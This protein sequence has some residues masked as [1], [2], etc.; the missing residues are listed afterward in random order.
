[1][2]FLIQRKIVNKKNENSKISVINKIDDHQG[3]ESN[4]KLVQNNSINIKKSDEIDIQSNKQI[5]IRKKNQ[6]EV[7]FPKIIPKKR[8][9][10]LPIV[11]DIDKTKYNQGILKLNSS[12]MSYYH[13]YF[14]YQLSRNLKSKNKKDNIKFFLD[15][16]RCIIKRKTNELVIK[17]LYKFYK[18]F[19]PK[20]GILNIN[21][22]IQEYNRDSKFIT[23][24]SDSKKESEFLEPS[25]LDL[26]DN[27]PS[28]LI[29]N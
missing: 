24:K 26:L 4:S 9:I 18:G 3:N 2:E 16:L 27:T 6:S 29:R 8:K 19:S 7:H 10:N 14:I 20:R 5:N 12:V 17:L 13:R 28:S 21:Y 11:T 25:K 22:E 23:G 15:T 1:M